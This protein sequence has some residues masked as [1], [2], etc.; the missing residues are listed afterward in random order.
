MVPGRVSVSAKQSFD[1]KKFRDNP[2][3]ISEYLNEALASDDLAVLV[4][5]IGTV[6]RAQ[7]V[8]ALSEETGLRRENLYRMFAGHRDPSLGNTLKMLAGFG[9]Q[10][11]VEPR[12]SIEV[13]PARPKLGR[14][15]AEAAD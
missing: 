2:A 4:A 6:M 3:L 13:K 14:P 7:T 8:V 10:F 1:P 5:A 9:V 15:K 12:A 11:A